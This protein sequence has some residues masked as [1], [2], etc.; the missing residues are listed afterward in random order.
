MSVPS[1]SIVIPLYNKGELFRKT[2]SS[3]LGQTFSD[4]EVIVVD[5][6]STD[7]SGDAAKCCKDP[8]VRYIYQENSGLPAAARNKGIGEAR[9]DYIAFLDADD[10]WYP[11]KLS[12]VYKAITS[13]PD[14]ALVSNNEAIKDEGGRIIRHVKYGPY[15]PEMFRRLLFRGNCLSPSAIIVRKSALYDV[16]LF[17]E[18]KY[19]FS[20]EDYDIWMRLAK[21]HKFYFL[22]EELGEFI[23]SLTN[24]SSG[25]ERHCNNQA[26]L[27]RKTF[28]EYEDRRPL[29]RIKINLRVAS[30]YFIIVRYMLRSGRVP[31]AFRYLSRTLTELVRTY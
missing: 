8:R 21:K 22:D 14:T 24:I 20:V 12:I 23:V 11:D 16:G 6:G 2:L 26:D 3:A 1:V 4:F 10:I 28:A 30:I 15:E 25:T 7:G 17:R 29:D 5:D 9:A 31:A 19:L 13:R 27:L 18:D